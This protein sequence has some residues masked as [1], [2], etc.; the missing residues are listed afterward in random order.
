MVRMLWRL[1][2][3][4]NLHDLLEHFEKKFDNFRRGFHR[5]GFNYQ[6]VQVSQLIDREAMLA[7]C[8]HL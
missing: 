4:E 7:L 3:V 8:K 2:S 6:S 5:Q 1:E